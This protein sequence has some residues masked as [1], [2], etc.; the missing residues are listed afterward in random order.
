MEILSIFILIIL[1]L[2]NSDFEQLQSSLELLVWHQVGQVFGYQIVV[3][4]V[5]QRC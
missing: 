3:V 4:M 2:L 5:E 1:Q